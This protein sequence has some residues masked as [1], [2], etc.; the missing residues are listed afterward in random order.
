[1]QLEVLERLNGRVQLEVFR[2]AQG[3]VATG[4]F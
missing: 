2:E 1:M 3:M 4:G